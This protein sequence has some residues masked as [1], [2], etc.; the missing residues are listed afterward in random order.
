M[1][2]VGLHSFRA[3]DALGSV[4]AAIDASGADYLVPG[5]DLAF[6]LLHRLRMQYPN[7]RSLVERSLGAASGFATLRSRFRTL[8]LAAGMGIRIPA[9]VPFTRLE[10]LNASELGGKFPVVLKRDGSSGGEGV[11][12]VAGAAA[13]P[14]QC[15]WIMRRPGGA[16]NL[17]RLVLFG[18][19]MG[20]AEAFGVPEAGFCAQEMIEGTPAMAMFACWEGRILGGL[21]AH[22]VAAQGRTG[23]ALMI[24]VFREE[25]MKRAGGLLAG[26]LGL[27][28]FFG[29][30]FVLS[31]ATG[32]QYLIDVNPWC[33][34]LGHI[35]AAGQA[36][37][38]GVLWAQWTGRPTPA[39][40]DKSLGNAIC[41]YPF[42]PEGNLVGKKPRH[43]RWDVGGDALLVVNRLF[44]EKTELVAHVRRL[45]C[46]ALRVRWGAALPGHPVHYFESPGD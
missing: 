31:E 11:A 10:E 23:P 21:E 13:L 39:P 34:Q 32:E 28:G 1:H 35:Q 27:S 44:K 36:D 22:V 26:A 12:M 18:D 40:G 7:Y 20:F 16:K 6:C 42:A 29:L 14:E 4:R 8:A 38:A 3:W 46:R 19:P 45:V 17:Q 33:N 43:T 15:A 2:I 25:R 30:D 5:D 9:C 41:F 24:E 37:L